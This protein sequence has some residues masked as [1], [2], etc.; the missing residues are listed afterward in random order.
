MELSGA[1]VGR[2]LASGGLRTVQQPFTIGTAGNAVE[3][4]DLTVDPEMA[5]R[6]AS[7]SGG[8]VA[9][10]A[11]FDKILSK[12]GPETKVVEEQKETSLW[13]NWIILVIA[14]T[15]LTAE[16]ILRRRHALA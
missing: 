16:W 5:A 2:L 12:F 1:D 9:S 4:G 10:L 13:D 11:D 7:L 3:L 14:V 8:V 15:A 6:L